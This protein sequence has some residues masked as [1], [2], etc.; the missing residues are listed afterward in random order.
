MSIISRNLAMPTIER[1]MTHLQ[2]ATVRA[3]R[4]VIIEKGGWGRH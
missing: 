2:T 4:V 3:S 1:R